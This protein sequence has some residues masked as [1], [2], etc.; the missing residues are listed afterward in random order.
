MQREMTE[1]G[2]VARTSTKI[3]EVGGTPQ[4]ADVVRIG[5]FIAMSAGRYLSYLPVQKSLV[6]TMEYAAGRW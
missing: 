1:S 2:R 6:V 4:Q 5:P 3:V